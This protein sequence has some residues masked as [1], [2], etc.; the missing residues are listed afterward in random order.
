[1]LDRRCVE[2]GADSC[3]K[4]LALIAIVVEHADFHEL[5]RSEVDID[6]VQHGRRKPVRADA[7]HR[8]QVMRLR[9]KSPPLRGC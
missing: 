2:I 3:K 5:V 1:M 7:H 4:S 9:A 8:M 6:L